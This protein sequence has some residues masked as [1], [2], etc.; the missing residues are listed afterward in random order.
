MKKMKTSYGEHL[1]FPPDD[2]NEANIVYQKI[3]DLKTVL[4]SETCY[5]AMN[6]YIHGEEHVGNIDLY[7][8]STEDKKLYV[9]N[10][11]T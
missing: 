10:V 11:N 7:V 6:Y 9:I 4:N 5:Y 3:E 2:P 8:I 1:H